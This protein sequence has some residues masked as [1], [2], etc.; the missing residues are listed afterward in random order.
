M[1]PSVFR[2]PPAILAALALGA[3]ADATPWSYF[4]DRAPATAEARPIATA[5]LPIA[6]AP[7]ASPAATTPRPARQA[8]YTPAPIPAGP[9][10]TEKSGL[11]DAVLTDNH[12]RPDGLMLH[13]DT[14][15]RFPLALAAT[16][17]P[18]G[19][20]LAR[21]RPIVVRGTWGGNRRRGQV[22]N[23]VEMGPDVYSMVSETTWR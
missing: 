17:D 8:A 2:I 1:V 13:D 4:S 20:K 3:C 9:A 11:I 14:V 7:V 19:S 10:L 21:G 15:I 6:A 22:L 16:M 12:G 23:A 18:D 5:P